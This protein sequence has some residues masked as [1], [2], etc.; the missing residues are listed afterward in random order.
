MRKFILQMS[1]TFD[2]IVVPEAKDAFDFTDQDM[3]DE[4][5]RTLETVDA[6]LI[7]GAAH[8]EYLSHW[9]EALTKPSNA[10]EGRFA[11]IAAKTPHWVLSRT[12]REVEWPNAKVLPG[13]VEGIPDLKKQAGGD[14]I[15]WGGQRV[16]D[17]ALQ[18]GVVDEI[19]LVTHPIIAGRGKKLFAGVDKLRKLRHVSTK[20]LPSG[21]VIRTYASPAAAK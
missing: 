19:R 15:L 18:M 8:R 1:I 7:G 11:K 5:F 12:L 16:A 20:P 3:W 4:H 10:N 17:A 9:Q 13:G 6:M 2:G 21:I 14:I